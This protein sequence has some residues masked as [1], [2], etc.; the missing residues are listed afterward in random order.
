MR[1]ASP[2]GAGSVVE[3]RTTAACN[4]TVVGEQSSARFLKRNGVVR[5]HGGPRTVSL[6]RLAEP[7]RV[8]LRMGH[9][10]YVARQGVEVTREIALSEDGAALSGE[11]RLSLVGKAA[12]LPPV[13]TRFHLH[14]TVRPERQEDGSVI[15][16]TASGDWRFT[17][18]AASL[19]IE[20]SA[21]FAGAEGARRTFQLVLTPSDPSSGLLRWRMTRLG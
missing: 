4:A 14:P 18:D 3:L 9:D 20:D 21:F 15:L 7:N 11:E 6:Q 13:L 1:L 5:L 17:P 8:A 16:R 19:E 10:G 2:R 12:T